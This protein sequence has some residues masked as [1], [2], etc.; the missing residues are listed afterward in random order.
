MADTR[1]GVHG[2]K[3]PAGQPTAEPGG[4]VGQQPP[5]PAPLA[6]GTAAGWVPRLAGIAAGAARQRE[7]GIILAGIIIFVI[8]SVTSGGQFDTA[9]TWGTIVGSAAELGIVTV[10]V[11][12]LM[13][14]GDFDLSVG[15]NFAFSALVMAIM[16]QHG[17]PAAAGLVVAAAIGA[18]IGLL[19]AFATLYFDIPSF[20]ATLGTWLLWS[21][22]TLVVAGGATITVFSSS[23]VLRVL[24]GPLFGQFSFEGVWWLVLAIVV[25]VVLHRTVFGNWVFAVGGRRQAAY[26]A[27][28]RVARTRTL[29][30]VAC[31]L[32]AALAGAVTLG[33]LSSMA[34][35]Y[36]T[37]Y[38]LYAIAAA[39][40]GGCALYGGRGS[41]FGAVIGSVILSM[42]DT[43]L[44]LSGV[45]TYW[46]Q[47]VVGIIVVL[48]VAMHTRVGR[49]IRGG[50]E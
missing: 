17:Y 50:G 16:I 18:G 28:V 37:Y 32:L 9:S 26:E 2:A 40:V 46:Y 47:A 48:A 35:S 30:F 42:L 15:A 36:G 7:S 33:H 19:N 11:A 8:F 12:M 4:V 41:I 1:G 27:G 23:P 39:V 13:V 6:P 31:G 22:I 10:G 38:Q 3:S 29:N 20:V 24:G 21:G 45:S 25:G 5:S 14:G 43:G 34:E 49:L 44:I